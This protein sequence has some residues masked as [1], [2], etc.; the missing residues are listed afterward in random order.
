MF[1]M[2]SSTPLPIE[3]LFHI[4]AQLCP[5]KD[6]ATLSAFS[7]TSST[8]RTDAQKRLFSFLKLTANFRW[9]LIQTEIYCEASKASRRFLT[10]ITQSPHLARLVKSLELYISLADSAADHLSFE[11]WLM[12]SGVNSLPMKEES[13]QLIQILRQLNRL[14]VF[15]VTGLHTLDWHD[16]TPE[17][18]HV[19]I[20]TLK[21]N[22]LRSISLPALTNFRIASLY[23][24]THL[25][26]LSLRDISSSEIHTNQLRD[27]KPCSVA[28]KTLTLDVEF[29]GRAVVNRLLTFTQNPLC[30]LTLSRLTHL[31]IVSDSISLIPNL[32]LPCANT[33]THLTFTVPRKAKYTYS[34]TPPTPDEIAAICKPI[35]LGSLPN[36]RKLSITKCRVHCKQLPSAP[37]GGDATQIDVGV[38][39]TKTS[40]PWVSAVL[41]TLSGRS[42][43]SCP[44]LVNIEIHVC[45]ID[46][47]AQSLQTCIPWAVLMRPLIDLRREKGIQHRIFFS[48][49]THDSGS[50]D[51]A[52]RKF[53]Y[54]S[55]LEILDSD[56]HLRH[57][58]ARSPTTWFSS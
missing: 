41:E 29:N 49:G 57:L 19:V 53:N 25:K 43:S 48:K 52:L 56:P 3:L 10:T 5:E 17:F 28:P 54:M 16:F 26:H 22:P 37:N 11:R 39:I 33:L 14:Q 23:R 58:H 12:L 13:T 45:L 8:F 35:D 31:T 18:K 34:A 27:Y 40:F 9:N 38:E 47:T 7:L 42:A 24:S 51:A 36:L 30:P 15:S 32:L 1:A 55:L 50:K 46:V 4:I 6:K 21:T 20:K 2:L 44:P